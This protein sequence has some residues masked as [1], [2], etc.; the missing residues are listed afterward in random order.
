MLFLCRCKIVITS[1]EVISYLAVQFVVCFV[2][3]INS[4]I[5]FNLY[6]DLQNS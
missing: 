2:R 5:A 4:I 1:L 3:V 6:D